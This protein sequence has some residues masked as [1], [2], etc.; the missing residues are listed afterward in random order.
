MFVT[1]TPHA[2]CIY[3]VPPRLLCVCTVLAHVRQLC[4]SRACHVCLPLVQVVVSS[5]GMY[6]VKMDPDD[7][8]FDRLRFM[9]GN[10]AYAQNKVRCGSYQGG[11]GT[12]A[13]MVG[14]MHTTHHLNQVGCSEKSFAS[15][16][17]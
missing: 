8:N 1:D 16:L 17:P 5:G 4:M 15:Q 12:M 9:Y 14:S 6:T 10:S 13:C 11:N 3:V 7:L 2:N